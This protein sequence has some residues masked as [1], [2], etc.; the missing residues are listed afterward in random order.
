MGSGEWGIGAKKLFP[1]HPFPTP[2]LPPSIRNPSSTLL[3]LRLGF[4][5]GGRRF[6]AIAIRRRLAARGDPRL[7]RLQLD[8]GGTGRRSGGGIQIVLVVRLRRHRHGSYGRVS[9]VVLDVIRA[10]FFRSSAELP[11]HVELRFSEVV[12]T[13]NFRLGRRR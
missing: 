11:V 6:S 3:A 7:S 4:A 12:Y 5:F 1:D 2:R 9:L 13:F 10:F 8:V